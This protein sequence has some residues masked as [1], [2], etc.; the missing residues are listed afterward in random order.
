MSREDRRIAKRRN[1]NLRRRV[2]TIYIKIYELYH[3]H[4]VDVAIFLDNKGKFEF[5]ISKESPTWPPSLAELVS[6][7]TIGVYLT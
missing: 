2:E 7:I 1:D 3:D 6:I 5:Y 4:G